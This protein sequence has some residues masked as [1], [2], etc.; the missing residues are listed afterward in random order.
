M[1]MARVVLE[2]RPGCPGCDG[3]VSE[4]GGQIGAPDRAV[5]PAHLGERSVDVEHP[6]QPGPLPAPVGHGQDGTAMAP[7]DREHVMAGRPD[8]RGYYKPGYAI[9]LCE[10]GEAPAR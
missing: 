2:C 3:P 1:D 10:N 6:H 9:Y 4:R 7:Q 8:G 5:R